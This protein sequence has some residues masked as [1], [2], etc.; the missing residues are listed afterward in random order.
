MTEKVLASLDPDALYGV[1]WFNTQRVETLSSG[2]QI[3]TPRPREDW[4]AVPIQDAGVPREWIEAARKRIEDNVRPSSAGRREWTLKGLAYCACGSRLKPFTARRP[5][6]LH[7]YM[8]CGNHRSGKDQCPH[9]RYLPATT[10][11]RRPDPEQGLEERVE[12]FELRLIEDPCVLRESVEAQAEEEKRTLGDSRGR[13]EAISRILA[14]ADGE[15][16]RYTRLYARGKLNDAEYDRYT[17]E[18]DARR[19]A[20]EE[21]LARIGDARERIEYLEAL[22]GMVDAYLRDLPEIGRGAGLGE[23]R[24]YE[25]TPEP[26]T[27]DNPLG[28]YTLTPDRIRER[29]NVEIEEIRRERQREHAERLRALYEVLGL[30]VVAYRDGTLDVSWG[31]GDGLGRC[32]L[33]GSGP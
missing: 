21:E 18:L 9:A 23:P 6:G 22:P 11:R 20:A 13:I 25:T 10:K 15:R 30:S 29:T 8:A 19:L 31:T 14:E 32:K 2:K 28:A 4:I 12:R 33:V 16:D 7:F 26:R 3:K 5:H 24:D 17:A 27:E 1:S